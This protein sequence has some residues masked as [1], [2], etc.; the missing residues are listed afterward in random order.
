MKPLVNHAHEMVAK[1]AKAIAEE[2]YEHMAH[3]N[4]FYRQWPTMRGFVARA[5]HRF[6]PQARQALTAI[7]AGDYPQPMKDEAYEALLKDSA[8]NPRKR[9]APTRQLL[10]H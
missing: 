9:P 5:W 6:H 7:V 10:L 2:F 1:T 8:I 4:A 3:D